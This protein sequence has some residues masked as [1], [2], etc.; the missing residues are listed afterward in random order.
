MLCVC[1]DGSFNGSAGNRNAI[2]IYDVD[3]IVGSVREFFGLLA[4]PAV[5]PTDAILTIGEPLA[6]GCYGMA[7]YVTAVDN[8]QIRAHSGGAGIGLTTRS[9]RSFTGL[10]SFTT[11]RIVFMR[12]DVAGYTIELWVGGKRFTDF[13]DTGSL[14]SFAGPRCDRNRLNVGAAFEGGD[15]RHL[16]LEAFA[17]GYRLGAAGDTADYRLAIEG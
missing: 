4:F 10:L 14:A 15:R 12:M 6:S 17:F 2:Q 13:V 7:I 16:P 5:T 11:A 3:R 8:L 1:N 9:H